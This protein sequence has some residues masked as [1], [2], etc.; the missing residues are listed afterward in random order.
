MEDLSGKSLL[1]LAQKKDEI[2]LALSGVVAE[3]KPFFD[4]SMIDIKSYG[5]KKNRYKFL[6]L[7]Y[8]KDYHQ[9]L[10]DKEGFPRED[11]DWG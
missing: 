6:L 2:E 3:M 8:I 1:E 4:K 5:E 9:N 11:L 10:V 7:K